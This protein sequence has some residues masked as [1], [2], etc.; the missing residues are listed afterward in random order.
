LRVAFHE[1]LDDLR[2]LS[3]EWNRLLAESCSD[4]IFL[5]WEWCEAW[6]K[7]YSEGR[8]LF[9]L[10][11]WE[12]SELIGIAPLY[13]EKKRHWGK[14]WTHLRLIGAGSGDSDYLDFFAKRG[15]E[16]SVVERFIV[17]LESSSRRWDWVELDGVPQTSLCLTALSGIAAQRE[18]KFISENSACASISLPRNWD[19]YL[20]G[21]RPRVRTKVRSALSYFEQDLSVAPT[22]C[23]SASEI[24]TWL[25][26]LFEVHTRRW[27]STS[28]SGVFG[29]ASRRSFYH[30]LSRSTLQQG[31]LAFHRLS[32]G[33]RPLALQF[34][35]HYHN[36]LYILQE[37]YDPAFKNLRPGI[38][39][40][41]WVIR[42]GIQQATEKYDFLEGNARHKLDWGARTTITQRVILTTK[43]S[44]AW[45]SISLPSFS[46]SLHDTA[47]DIV[48]QPLR[49]WRQGLI[50]SRRQRGFHRAQTTATIERFTR[51]AISRLYSYTPLG[52]ASRKFADHYAS[53][54]KHLAVARDSDSIPACMIFR[55]HHVNDHYDPFFEA[56]PVARF[57][58]QMEHL[59]KYF[60]LVSLDQ[61]IDG[62]LSSN[63]KRCSVAITFDDGY[64][65]NFVHA[66]PILKE[67][68][69]PATIF[70]TTGYIESGRLP[71]YDQVRL[72]FKLTAQ[73]HFSLPAKSGM[74]ADLN[75]DAERLKAM[76]QALSWLRM[77][78]DNNRLSLLP[79][80]FRD[81]RVPTDLNLP[82][83]MLEWDE[84]RKMSKQGISFGAHTV[85][86]PVL[87]GL[88]AT[89]LEDEIIGSK[90]TIEARLQAPVRH[91][92]YPFGKYVDFDSAARKTVEA[93][94]F[95]TAV[96]TITGVNGPEQDPLE[97]KR[98]SL[99]EPDRGLFGL[100][101]D[102]SRMSA[103]TMQEDTVSTSMRDTKENAQ[104]RDSLLGVR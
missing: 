3:G 43:T 100:K 87:G 104:V 79:E 35:F 75:T 82:G 57:R 93:A 27:K 91:F 29:N 20:F 38:A 26:Q 73:P 69:I 70:L 58:A 61:F 78:T 31:W 97:L 96:T 8:S 28:K 47:R 32:W 14:T 94:G 88:S 71:W 101:L 13:A 5:T 59:A 10:S 17:F 84:I 2:V 62:G 48:P 50:V 66:F 16:H 51:W 99:D 85:T 52:A 63:S 36:R 98:L 12:G 41:A 80:L 81:L 9:V 33:E 19:D 103:R 102:W 45:I 68:G 42:D 44:A 95:S 60:H 54:V 1:S 30:D 56:L 7:A 11:A 89:R 6:W 18:W 22:Q 49:S 92:A 21:L 37:G 55:Y 64:R 15:Q 72:G 24:K 86:H 67:L 90:K 76:R 25:E 77:T 46:Q 74:R 65:D 53:D 34:G 23:S 39:L 83:T 4:T 40:R